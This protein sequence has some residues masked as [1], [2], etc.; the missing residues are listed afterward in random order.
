M[1]RIEKLYSGIL[2]KKDGYSGWPTM[3]RLANG[4]LLVVCSGKRE[5][6][7]C[8]F[9]RVQL[10]RSTDEGHTWSEPRELSCGPLDDRDAGI[11]QAADGT[12]LLNYFTNILALSGDPE[13]M[14]EEWKRKTTEITLETLSREHGFWMRRSPDSG[15]TW[16][17]KYLIPVNSPHGPVQMND[18]SLLFVGKRLSQSFAYQYEGSRLGNEIAA[19]QSKDNGLSWKIISVLPIAEGHTATAC[20]EPYAIQMPSGRI[21]ATI[22]DQSLYPKVETWQTESEDG[23]LT[24]TK[25]HVLQEG[26]PAHLLKFTN[27]RLL[28]TY[29]YRKQP[30]GIRAMIS[31][32]SGQTWNN[33][34]II[35]DEGEGIDLGYP[36]TTVMPD[37]SFFTVWY[38]AIG[39]NAVI[40]FSRW[41][42]KN[43]QPKDE[44]NENRKTAAE[45]R[46]KRA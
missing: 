1:I 10:Y 13:K 5:A 34:F 40:K 2:S 7:I 14:P 36:T 31:D 37:G 33:E 42:L 38:E 15:Y 4:D 44:S 3:I 35:Y 18:G 26:Y 17:E 16:G 29:G 27:G 32:D 9:G 21:I 24:W 28:M 12:L 23:G 43:M 46:K 45:C 25:P 8:P 41:R 39:K 22:R 20:F 30:F 11:C 6:H 19:A